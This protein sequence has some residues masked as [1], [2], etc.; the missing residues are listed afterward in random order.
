M[1]ERSTLKLSV[2]FAIVSVVLLASSCSNDVRENDSKYQLARIDSLENIL[3]NGDGSLTDREAATLII[4]AFAQYYQQYKPD[5]LAVDMLFKAGEVSMGLADGSL[6]VKYFGTVS[7]SHPNF[8]KAPEA[9]FLMGFCEETINGNLLQAQAFYES[10]IAAHPDH[11]LAADARFS[12]VNL[13]KTDEE[14]IQLFEQLNA[15]K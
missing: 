8:E 7:E 2:W 6:A 10:F 12:I 13:G 15:G 4:K 1:I 3:Y 14:L 5:S 9:M 11:A